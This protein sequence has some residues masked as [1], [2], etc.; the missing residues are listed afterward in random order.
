MR[1]D[2]VKNRTAH[3]VI[4]LLLGLAA[5]QTAQSNLSAVALSQTIPA[6]GTLPSAT[7]TKQPT[8]TNVFTRTLPL[9]P[10]A[11]P[12]SFPMPDLT[13]A[14]PYIRIGNSRSTSAYLAD[15]TG[16]GLRTISL[17]EQR[18]LSPDSKWYAYV[19][20]KLGDNTGYSEEGIVLHVKNIFT[21]EIR[22]VANLVPEDAEKHIAEI[23][24][25]FDREFPPFN[26]GSG[27]FIPEISIEMC[28]DDGFQ[29]PCLYLDR[30]WHLVDVISL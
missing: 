3:L 6:S 10:T 1:L 27:Y 26:G 28:L 9:T 22:D 17:P 18:I 24:K 30:R 23:K 4:L 29:I 19:T 21:E 12:T 15:I 20:G 11:T 13:T 25:E 2:M 8:L 7:G 16:K 14:G 5:C